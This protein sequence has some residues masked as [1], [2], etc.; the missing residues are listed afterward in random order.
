MGNLAVKPAVYGGFGADGS[1][2]H[3]KIGVLPED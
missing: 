1:V 3:R 2:L